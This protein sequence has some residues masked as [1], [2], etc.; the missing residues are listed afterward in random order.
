M[1]K[2]L[3][4]TIL[5]LCAVVFL[6]GDSQSWQPPAASGRRGL[7]D[8]LRVGQRVTLVPVVGGRVWDVQFF[9]A[10][11]RKAQ[12]PGTSVVFEI[13]EDFIGFRRETQELFVPVSSIRS[14]YRYRSPDDPAFK[15]T[16]QLQDKL[17]AKIDI[18]LRRTPFYEAFNIIGKK[19]GIKFEIEANALKFEGYTQ[20]MT[21]DL[22][23]NL[24]PA[25]Q[26]LAALLGKYKPLILVKDAKRQVVVVTTKAA[27]KARPVIS[28]GDGKNV[29]KT[30]DKGSKTVV[31]VEEWKKVLSKETLEQ[32]IKNSRD[33]L[34]AKLASLNDFKRSFPSIV[35]EAEWLAALLTI[36]AEHPEGVRWKDR[37]PS[38][39]VAVS[40]LAETKLRS[41][42]WITTGSSRTS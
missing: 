15:F 3:T 32:E 5:A 28:L 7:L 6:A 38:M 37:L 19:I 30:N 18:S 8:V 1:K 31:K 25:R 41:P 16:T 23:L 27:R 40:K 13:G 11:D 42:K 36:A 34:T 12:R 10:T 17:D 22:V 39:V 21:Q 2:L 14:M 24:T 35:Q 26:V 29:S 20:N 33:G 9:H 4:L